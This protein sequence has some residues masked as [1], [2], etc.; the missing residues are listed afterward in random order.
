MCQQPEQEWSRS[1]A[2]F[3]RIGVDPEPIFA[4][5]PKQEAEFR[6][7]IF[8]VFTAFQAGVGAKTGAGVKFFRVGEESE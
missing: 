7:M 2:G 8:V 4:R 6:T 1:S 3:Y 5:K